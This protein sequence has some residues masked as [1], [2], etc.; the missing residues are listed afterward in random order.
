MVGDP[1]C[2]CCTRIDAAQ[3]LKRRWIGIDVTF[4]AVDLINGPYVGG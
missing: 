1:F 4:I 3:R 2:G